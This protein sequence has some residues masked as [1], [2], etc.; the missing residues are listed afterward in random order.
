[1]TDSRSI[2]AL[3]R[4]VYGC[5][6]IAEIG[7]ETND[8]YIFHV[9]VDGT[10]HVKSGT[11][12]GVLYAAYDAA[13]GKRSGRESPEFSI[14]GLN[15]C[16]SL[17]RH[18]SGQ[19]G[20][21][22]DRMGR[23]RMNTLLIH[24]N[25]GFQAH[26]ALIE[27]E[28][29]RRGIELVHYT[30]SNLCFLDGIA[31]EHFAKGSDGQP[32]WKRAECETRLC[33]SDTEGLRH[34]AANVRRYLDA[35]P[36]YE[37]LLF[38]TADGA[39]NCRCVSCAGKN[40]IAQWHPVFD[41]FFDAAHGRRKLEMLAYVQRFSVPSDLSRV[42]KLDRV[43]F[44]MH[45]RYPRTPF[46][47]HHEWM[48]TGVRYGHDDALQDSRGYCPINV[49]LWDRLAEWREAFKGQLYVFENLMIQGIWGCPRPNTSIYLEDLR[50]FRKLGIAGVVYE[51]FEPGIG[52]FLPTFDAIAATM[53]NLK[54]PY[55][56][57]AFEAAYLAEGATCATGLDMMPGH[58]KWDGSRGDYPCE[59]LAQLLYRRELQRNL[60]AQDPGYLNPGTPGHRVFLD[61]CRETLDHVLEHPQRETFDW[62]YIA[63]YV[64]KTAQQL[65]AINPADERER[66][67][68]ESV[69]LWDFQERHRP[70]REA[71]VTAIETLWR[72]FSRTP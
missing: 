10:L 20:R 12:R 44:D 34:Y 22:I 61:C 72:R 29:A 43:L 15:P 37:R 71:A 36:D 8:A 55:T 62:I 24:S 50:N 49:Y 42:G 35:H 32:M 33:V 25:Y 69:K 40:A 51:A 47:V 53:W 54:A 14:R 45:L 66:E 68:L 60:A 52:P 1:M 18:T 28:A 39:R 4:E 65:G 9:G 27:L 46:G 56:P 19:I 58:E 57:T 3:A 7:G 16:E 26:R 48:K 2:L 67:F 63:C 23:W 30:Y 41:A 17:N 31:P 11:P 38:A 21:L 70:P 6:V 5:E 64:L 13:S 59:R